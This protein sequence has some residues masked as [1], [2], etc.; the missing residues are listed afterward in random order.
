MVLG[1]SKDFIIV[2]CWHKIPNVIVVILYLSV[3]F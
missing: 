3:L 2:V 1:Q